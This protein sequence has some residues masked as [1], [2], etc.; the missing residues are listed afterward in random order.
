[1]A[2]DRLPDVEAL[3]FEPIGAP[4]AAKMTNRTER[5][6]MTAG[7]AVVLG[8]IQRYLAT[9]YYYRL[10]LLEVQKLAYFMQCAGQTLNLDFK[11]APYGPYAN[12]LRH[13]LNRI[14]GHFI[15]GFGDGN[16]NPDT[17]ISPLAPALLEAE[18]MLAQHGDVKARFDR[19]SNLIEGFETP[20]GMELI[21]SVHW[22]ITQENELASNDPEAAIF[23]VHTWSPRKR[24]MFT[25]EHI[26]IAW[27]QLN[28]RGW[29]E[30]S[31]TSNQPV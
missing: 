17:R 23:G 3:V 10:S 2:F 18:Q 22:V 12:K 29:L 4:A 19:V 16:N 14:E 26:R 31:A 21:S 24:C 15:V 28:E 20:Y 13:V 11:R 1:M 25:A 27:N 9:D 30:S 5:P 8:L 7:R 6:A